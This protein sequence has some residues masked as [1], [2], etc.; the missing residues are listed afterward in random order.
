M[1]RFGLIVL[2]VRVHVFLWALQWEL[3]DNPQRG[4]VRW[5]AH[6]LSRWDGWL[7]CPQRCAAQSQPQGRAPA[8]PARW[9]DPTLMDVPPRK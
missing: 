5:F 7:Q 6:H 8:P 3:S 4:G 2:H 9:D 1:Q